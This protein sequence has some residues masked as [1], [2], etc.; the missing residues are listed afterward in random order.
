VIELRGDDRARLAEAERLIG[1][2][3]D[4]LAPVLDAGLDGDGWFVVL[5][6]WAGPSLEQLLRSDP[7]APADV[8]ALLHPIASGLDRLHE[9]GV[10][11]RAFCAENV[12]VS[13]LVEPRLWIVGHPSVPAAGGSADGAATLALKAPEGLDYVP[14]DLLDGSERPDV[15]AL[16]VLAFRLLA[17]DLPFRRYGT[18][19]QTLV[20]RQARP[21]ARVAELARRPVQRSLED[22]ARGVLATEER[23]RPPTAAALV[24]ELALAAGEPVGD[25]TAASRRLMVRAERAAPRPTVMGA[26]A[27]RAARESVA[28]PTL[29]PHATE[30]EIVVDVDERIDSIPPS[31]IDSI[32]P[33]RV[34][35]HP[36]P[37]DAPLAFEAA[38]HA[39]VSRRSAS[40]RPS[41]GLIVWCL[42]L[43]VV[44]LIAVVSASAR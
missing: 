12:V 3:H 41:A 7:L 16:A 20:E 36:P 40:V 24:A 21:A 28:A 31:R 22:W 18:L 10:T 19:T 26:Q 30:A 4:G 13:S 29:P 1:V 5:D 2:A 35:S 15:Y 44:A 43:C 42:L 23:L 14:P 38:L 32:P 11:H 9:V 37:S 17:G 33:A 34:D 27:V 6:R 25:H 8:V 39:P